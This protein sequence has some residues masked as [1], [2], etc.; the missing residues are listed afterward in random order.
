MQRGDVNGQASI[1]GAVAGAHFARDLKSLLLSGYN[2]EL[3][4][5]TV[6]TIITVLFESLWGFLAQARVYNPSAFSRKM[7]ME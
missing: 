1:L 6:I 5:L 3:R 2:V 7:G 4:H